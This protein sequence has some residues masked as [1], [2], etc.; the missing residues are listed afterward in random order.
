MRVL[1]TGATGLIGKH[2]VNG[3]TESGYSVLAVDMRPYEPQ[4]DVDFKKG[5]VSDNDFLAQICQGVDAIIHLGSIPRPYANPDDQVFE[6]NSVG[7]YRV[8]AAAVAAGIKTVC[9]A[10]SLSIY[11]IAW[12]PKPTSPMYV[13][14]DELHPLVHFD[15]YA[16]TKEVNERSADMWANRS[17]T[18]FIGFRF[19]FCNTEKEIKDFK[20][21]MADGDEATLAIGA[22][23]FWSYLDVRDACA[24]LIAALEKPLMGSRT[25][26]F[27][28]PDTMAPKSTLEMLAQYHPSAIIKTPISGYSSILDQSAWNR[29]YGY[30]PVHL[31]NRT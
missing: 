16:L 24:G 28:A 18:S 17:D 14:M 11:G 3:L 27:A 15:T 26:N 5:N 12:S 2:V 25:Y 6:N 31:I 22:A 29:D 23:I 7:T 9:Y 13:P 8:F 4:Q 10:S 20:E 21:K 19:P 30:Q 1:L